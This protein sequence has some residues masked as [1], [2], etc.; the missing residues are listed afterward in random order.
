[1]LKLNLVHKEKS[2]IDYDISEF[3][4]GEQQIT[5]GEIDHKETVRVQCRITCANE[6]FILMQVMDILE[7]QEIVYHLEIA[8]LMGMRMD[9]VMDYNRP[10]T[11]KIVGEIL[12]KS[13]AISIEILEPHST[14]ISTLFHNDKRFAL[15]SRINYFGLFVNL[16]AYQLVFPD[17]GAYLR[18]SGRGFSPSDSKPIRC[19]KVRDVKTGKI[20]S[21]EVENPEDL[22][23][24]ELLVIDDLCD[25][26]GTFVGVAKALQEHTDVR[27]SIAVIHMVNPDGIRRLSETYDHVWFTNSHSDWSKYMLKFPWNCVEIDVI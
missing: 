8:Y 6:L 24:R 7:R 17:E 22:D 23:G 12:Q 9:R 2:D 26:G 3:P 25:A 11:L 5:L 27:M 19:K 15:T 20:L 14:R 21:I 1:M 13:K 16:N 18:Y 4:D 10:F